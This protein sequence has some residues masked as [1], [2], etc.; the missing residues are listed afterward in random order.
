V[1]ISLDSIDDKNSG[2]AFMISSSTH[3]SSATISP[4][5]SNPFTLEDIKVLSSGNFEFTL[6]A[7]SLGIP[8]NESNTFT[9]T[10]SIKTLNFTTQPIS[11][12][13]DFVIDF[14]VIGDD[15]NLYLGVST[16][17]IIEE[18]SLGLEGDLNYSTS[19]GLVTTK[20]LYF[21]SAGEASLKYQVNSIAYE[22]NFTVEESKLFIEM[23]PVFII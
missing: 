15:G 3:E 13:F 4:V 5:S 8:T 18:S 7:S 17:E 22:S 11:N 2:S 9:S 14:E 12:Y 6:N 1:T 19:T 21:L 23:S 20:G 16:L 10:N